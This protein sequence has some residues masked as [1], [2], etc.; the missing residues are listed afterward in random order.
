MIE[1]TLD[2]QINN[3]LISFNS[4]F[5][6]HHADK[7]IG[8]HKNGFFLPK[9]VINFTYIVLLFLFESFWFKVNRKEPM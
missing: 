4:L 9:K 3:W 8:F 7:S 1:F 6:E 2:F 5:L